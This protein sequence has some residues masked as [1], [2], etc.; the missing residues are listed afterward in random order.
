[1]FDLA[2]DLCDWKSE[3]LE[4][5]EKAKSH[6]CPECGASTTLVPGSGGFQIRGFSSAN[7]YHREELMYDG[8]QPR[9]W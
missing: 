9:D 4:S 3:V 1:M 5:Y 8:S 2:C 6:T 7:N